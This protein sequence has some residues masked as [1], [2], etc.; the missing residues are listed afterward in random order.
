M[1]LKA[2]GLSHFGGNDEIKR[3]TFEGA[4]EFFWDLLMR[5]LRHD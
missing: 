1:Y 4:S 5:N 2:L 3:L